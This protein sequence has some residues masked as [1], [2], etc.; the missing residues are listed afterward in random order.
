MRLALHGEVQ[1]IESNEFE[2]TSA[3]PVSSSSRIGKYY[4]PFIGL[5]ELISKMQSV[6][7]TTPTS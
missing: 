6:C 7:I 4:V 3:P 1:V 2:E 5:Y